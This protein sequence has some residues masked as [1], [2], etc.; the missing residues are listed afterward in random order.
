MKALALCI[1]AA[2]VISGA[3]INSPNATLTYSLNQFGNQFSISGD[4][5]SVQGGSSGPEFQDLFSFA[6]GV[7]SPFFGFLFGSSFSGADG[8]ILG[9]SYSTLDVEGGL[10]TT[11]TLPNSLPPG[12]VTLIEPGTVSATVAACSSCPVLVDIP[13][14]NSY[15]TL[16]IASN[17]VLLNVTADNFSSPEPATLSISGVGMMLLL[18]TGLS[19]RIHGSR[20]DFR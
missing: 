17:Y 9:T 5:F 10:T 12:G 8:T 3:E 13:S 4:Q 2:S 19:R 6:P 16:D 20:R 11:F 18:L 15:L 7:N 1:L 14:Q